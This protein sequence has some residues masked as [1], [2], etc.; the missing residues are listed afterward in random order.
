MSE[1]VKSYDILP[2]IGKSKYVDSIYKELKHIDNLRKRAEKHGY[3]LILDNY[4]HKYFLYQPDTCFFVMT[5]E[6]PNL[7]PA[8]MTVDEVESTLDYFDE[9]SKD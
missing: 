1:Y 4:T 3:K 2:K 6:E 5:G 8:L 9:L 7:V